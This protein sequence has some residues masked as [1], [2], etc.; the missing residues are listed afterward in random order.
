M[1]RPADWQL[2]PGTDRGLWDYLHSPLVADRYD[3]GLAG[4][5]LTRLDD[6]FLARH[7]TPPGWLL[8]LGCGTG[9][10][11]IAAAR[12]GHTV[13]GVDLSPTMLAL[14]RQRLAAA[15][16]SAFLVRANLV[17]L[18]T[19]ADE[20][21]D[22]AVCLFSTLGMILGADARRRVVAHAFRVLRPGG[23][24]LVHAHAY[25]F[26]AADPTGRKWLIG[27][28]FNR[29][30]GRPTGDRP[31]PP[32]NGV[33]G[34]RLHHFRRRELLALLTDVGFHIREVVPVRLSHDGRVSG[35]VWL[36]GLRTCGYLVA[37]QRPSLSRA[38]GS[39]RSPL[40]S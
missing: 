37:A 19:F 30:F 29:L 7:C 3:T 9:R 4:H 10:S 8:D 11:L 39:D 6:E 5:P 31:M 34:L 22:H 1:S 12:L 14:A 18:D 32:H 25:W 40:P 38:A 23:I 17:Q 13:V 36:R 35:P 27:D 28:L 16:V 33:A 26:N 24:F 21:F 2:P 20:S 15:S